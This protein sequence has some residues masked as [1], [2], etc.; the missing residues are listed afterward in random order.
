MARLSREA[1][2]AAADEIHR[3][4]RKHRAHLAGAYRPRIVVEPCQ[5]GI[6][7]VAAGREIDEMFGG[8]AADDLGKRAAGLAA[9][10]SNRI[11]QDR[12][13]LWRQRLAPGAFELQRIPVGFG[14]NDSAVALLG[15]PS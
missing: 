4:V 8:H 5:D 15:R 2:P 7:E 14:E 11:E 10:R 13:E 1:L 9:G 6:E 3:I 12:E